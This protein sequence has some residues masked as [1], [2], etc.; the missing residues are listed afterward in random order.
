MMIHKYSPFLLDTQND[1]YSR[2]DF[3]DF[4]ETG[5]LDL[6]LAL[7]WTLSDISTSI[8]SQKGR[9]TVAQRCWE[10]LADCMSQLEE[11][12]SPKSRCIVDAFILADH[13]HFQTIESS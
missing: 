3:T 7:N 6:D 4:F 2:V 12:Y 9:R 8:Q 13:H 10:Q 5:I 11:C 1:N